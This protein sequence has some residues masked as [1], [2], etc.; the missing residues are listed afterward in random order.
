MR[1]EPEPV[2]VDQASAAAVPAEADV[3]NFLAAERVFISSV[4]VP[5]ADER[6][7]VAAAISELGAEP[8]WFETFGGRDADPEAAYLSEVRSSTIYVGILGANY[9][10]ILPS[11]FSATHEEYREAERRGL[12]ISVWTVADENWDGDQERFV[13]EVR[14]FHVTGSYTSRE[15]LAQGVARRLRKIAAE[16]LSPWV[17][18]GSLILRAS[19]IVVAGTSLSI[20]AHVRDAQVAD[21]LE[22]LRPGRWGGQEMQFTDPSRSIRVRVRDVQ[23]TAVSAGSRELQIGAE[24]VDV[25][26]TSGLDFSLQSHGR[27]YTPNDLTELALREHLFGEI[28]PAEPG[29]G[30]L[31]H[32]LAAF[33]PGIAEDALRPLLRLFLNEA[34]VGGGRASRLVAL[35]LGVPIAGTRRIL[36][37]WEGSTRYSN[38]SE[39]RSIEGEI[40]I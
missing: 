25:S 7:G 3:R 30:T 13:Q 11:R 19:Q 23:S 40:S 17:K 39:R 26:G 18:L 32:P 29:F 36:I 14:T 33:P 16:E 6:A 20:T 9:G 22:A 12:R 37:E 24:I 38:P 1:S 34:L 35:R 21:A 8:I 27:T 4:M 10:R 2:L 28:N 15:N 5:L 31:P